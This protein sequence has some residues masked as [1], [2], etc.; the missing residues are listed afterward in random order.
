MGVSI[1]CYRQRIGC[2][3]NT[4]VKMKRYSVSK[5]QI[6]N[7]RTRFI[8]SFLI[9]TILLFTLFHST[10][11][12]SHINSSSA[13]TFRTSVNLLKGAKGFPIE[14]SIRNCRISWPY[15]NSGNNL[16]HAI[17]GNKRNVGYKYL[18]W[19]CGRGF[20]SEHKIDDLKMTINRHRPHVVAVSEVDFLRCENN[21]DENANNNFSTNQLLEKTNI[22]DYTV[23]LPKSWDAIGKARI[24]V[25]VRDDLKTKHI[26]PQD[27]YYDHVQNITLEIGFGKS[28]T[29]FCNFYYR[30][31]TSCKNGRKDLQNQL[32]DLELLLDIWRNCTAG[33][34]D[35]VAIGDMNLCAKRW[36]ET[37]YE[38]K[39]LA[40]KVV[41]FMYEEECSQLVDSFT[42]I[43]SVAGVV[44][45]SCLD[46]ATVN[47]VNKISPPLII[48]VGK[49]DHLGVL[50][51]KSSKEVRNFARTTRKRIYKNFDKAAFLNDVQDAKTAGRF[52]GV[53]EAD[54]PDEAFGVF[55]ETFCE[56][57]NRH[58]PLKVMQNRTDYVPYISP[59]LR[60]H[61]D[62]RDFL[63]ETAADTG[64]IDDYDCYKNKRNE[65]S[66]LMK[67]AEKDYHNKKFD[68]DNTSKTVWKT[69]YD[70]LGNHRTSF[71]SQILHCG[72][73][74]SNPKEI[75]TEV[76][77]FFVE[78]IRKLKEEFKPPENEDPTV[79]LKKY[80][81]KKNVP[82]EG[83]ALRE[84]SGEDVK[85][86]LKNIKGKRA[87]GM[88][89]ICG[90]SLKI[91]SNILEEE[92]KAI[93]N[94][95]IKKKQ[96][97]RKWKC[98]KI[99]PGW[100]NKG[101]RYELKFYRPISNLSEVSKLVERA[102][103][104]Q[105]YEYLDSNGLIHPNHHG[106]LKHSST[107]SALQHIL[108]IWLQHLDKGKLSAAL[109][110]DLSAGF[111]VINH[112]VL[113]LK[114]KEYNFLEDTISWFSSYL[115]DRSQCVQVESSLSPSLS[116]PWGVPQGSI[117]GPLLFLLFIN[118]LP[119]IVKEDLEVESDVNDPH[120]EEEIIVYADDN[121][122]TTADKNPIILQNKIQNEA[123]LVTNWFSKND[124]VCSSDKTKLLIIG[125]HANRQSKLI[126]QNLTLSV[127]V[128]GEAKK[129]TESEKLLGVIV[130]NTATFKHHLYGDDDNTGLLK[131]LSQRVGMLK[132]LKKF[133]SP[134]RLKMVMD[135]IFGSKLAYGMTVWGRV[136]QIPGEDED[137]RS[138]TLT[139]EDIRKLQ[140]LQN[141]CLR[142]I[143]NC[144]YKTPTKVLLQKTNRLSVHQQIAQLSLSQ[145][146]SIY[147][148][149]SPAYH[150]QRLFSRPHNN[151]EQ[152]GTRSVDDYSANR[153]DFKLSL[154]RSN[155]FYQSSRLWAAIPDSIKMI[156]KK[157]IFKKKCKSWV[158]SNVLVKP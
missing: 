26:Q 40:N 124:M 21:N 133:M 70:V 24:I 13:G 79:E 27:Q 130:N 66:M 31:W 145:V 58:A 6:L 140:V 121:T 82:R 30:E 101:T 88:D 138:P 129:E 69:A 123:D 83:F 99:L 37:S 97:V 107:S 131:Q 71:P 144:D 111:D 67:T 72:R 4:G 43:R 77:K 135:G 108:D 112:Q 118:E 119:D 100:K 132:R 51:T 46:H 116:V 146:H 141:K 68:E 19:N 39:D 157:N 63:K 23:Y 104:D 73:L 41:D 120:S 151:D 153:I 49:S 93:I 8:F 12:I 142:L 48:G 64:S 87:S 9:R 74:L 148:T 2:F 76:N 117:L 61:M 29:H 32:D 115:L 125:T 14:H 91:S 127:N 45:R 11:S 102:V 3:K 20:L 143:T 25:Y 92:L 52:A 96:F 54:N 128:C 106:F 62:E 65:V 105:L 55:E 114:M 98:S 137:M 15:S 10:V 150:Y 53:L 5:N 85:K 44:Q 80:L 60:K 75:A 110:L 155:F 109:F 78:K 16:I 152:Q 134:A 126:N 1:E 38:H 158:M 57:L 22:Q 103:Y 113:L 149:R 59:E 17:C 36:T 136:W 7:I 35:F 90:F 56:I 42:R 95:C 34:K 94:I 156:R 86:L 33:D 147:Y 28:K 47:C 84:L 89:W 50:L 122:P 139:K 18:S 154:A 81:S